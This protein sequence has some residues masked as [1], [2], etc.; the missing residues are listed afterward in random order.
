MCIRPRL[1]PRP[2]L[3]D[4]DQDRGWSETGLVIRPRSQTTR[5]VSES[6]V[7][8]LAGYNVLDLARPKVHLYYVAV[9]P[10]LAPYVPVA[11][12]EWK[13]CGLNTMCPGVKERCVVTSLDNQHDRHNNNNNNNNN[14]S[15]HCQCVGGY[16][17]RGP[18]EPCRR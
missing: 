12:P 10:T 2:K 15:G 3:Q 8:V 9:G 14:K 5:L 7:L 17:R 1:R 18:H 13:K 4:S 11:G 16:S 6:F